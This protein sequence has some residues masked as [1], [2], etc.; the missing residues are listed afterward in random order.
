M[1]G[2]IIIHGFIAEISIPLQNI[3]F[4]LATAEQQLITWKLIALLIQQ[5]LICLSLQPFKLRLCCCSF[6]SVIPF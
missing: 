2:V 1:N 3:I 4:P 5:T 6:Y